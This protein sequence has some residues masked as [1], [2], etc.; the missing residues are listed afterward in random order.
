MSP[1]LTWEVA[2]EFDDTQHQARPFHVALTALAR[3]SQTSKEPV[4]LD[5]I[6]EAQSNTA[7]VSSTCIANYLWMR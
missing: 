7:C 4:V 5:S 2:N 1:R 6:G 3:T